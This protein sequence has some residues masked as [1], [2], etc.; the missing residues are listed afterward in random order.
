LDSAV[1]AIDTNQLI[2][3][4]ITPGHYRAV[5]DCWTDDEERDSITITKPKVVVKARGTTS[6]KLKE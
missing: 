4:G 6:V 5:I 3:Q 1:A 2:L